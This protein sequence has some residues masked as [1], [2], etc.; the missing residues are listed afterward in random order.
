MKS[1]PVIRALILL[2][3]VYVCTAYGP[4]WLAASF[5]ALFTL[6]WSDKRFLSILTGAGA[7]FF[8]FLFLSVQQLG[9]DQTGLIKK[10]GTLFM[11]LS[12]G[13]FVAVTCLIGIISGALA[14][15][16]GHALNTRIRN[17]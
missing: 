2:A 11:D 8:V 1:N 12:P 5:V 7:M 16:F 17:A 14:G 9:Q 13:A 3:G 4:W 15:L 10:T 6:L